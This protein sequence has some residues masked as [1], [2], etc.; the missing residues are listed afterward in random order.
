M[1]TTTPETAGPGCEFSIV[2]VPRRHTRQ[3][4]PL[5]FTICSHERTSPG[6]AHSSRSAEYAP[7]MHPH[8]Q[9]ARRSVWWPEP[10][11]NKRAKTVLAYASVP[12][13]LTVFVLA[14]WNRGPQYILH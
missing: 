1:L 13:L 4:T 2:S 6:N 10:L 3:S 5:T 14:F 11:W 9:M 8:T 12:L 7:S